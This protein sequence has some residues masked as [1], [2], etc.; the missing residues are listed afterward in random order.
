M[1]QV[2]RPRSGK[3]PRIIGQILISSD[4]HPSCFFSKRKYDNNIQIITVTHIHAFTHYNNVAAKNQP[5]QSIQTSA[6]DLNLNVSEYAALCNYRKP[7]AKHGVV[8]ST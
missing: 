6:H 3:R 8:P 4:I 2:A 5:R 1:K 7:G